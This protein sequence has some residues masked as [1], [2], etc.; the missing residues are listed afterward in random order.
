MKG[1]NWPV[2]YGSDVFVRDRQN[3]DAALRILQ[4]QVR[5]CLQEWNDQCTEAIH[6]YLKIGYMM[7]GYTEEKLSVEERVKLAWTA[8]CFVCLWKAWMEMSSYT[9]ESSFISLQTY[10]DM[11]LAGHTLV[12]SLKLFTKHFLE[13]HFHPKVF[14]SDSCERL[15][16]RLIGFY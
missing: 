5:Q 3:V 7:R 15:F 14:G 16:A 1:K 2:V 10:N 11:I 6:I 4:P 9:T 12:I 8:V 13:E